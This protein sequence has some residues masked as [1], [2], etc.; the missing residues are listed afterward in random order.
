MAADNFMQAIRGWSQWLTP[1]ILFAV[2]VA[3]AGFVVSTKCSLASQAQSNKDIEDSLKRLNGQVDTL[4]AC[5]A[6]AGVKQVGQHAPT[7]GKAGSP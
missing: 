2:L 4:M 1:A 5:L 6:A 3:V 7:P